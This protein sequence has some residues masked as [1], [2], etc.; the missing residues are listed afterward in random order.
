M[1]NEISIK[2]VYKS[3]PGQGDKWVVCDLNLEIALGEFFCFVG[4]SGCGKTTTLKLIVGLEPVTKGTIEK[5]EDITMIFQSGALFP[6][7]SVWDN[8]AFGLKMENQ[9]KTKIKELTGKYL[10]MVRLTSF[11]DKYPRELSGGQRQRVGI[12]RALAVSPRVLLLDEPFSALD[13]FTTQELH[14]DL[15]KIWRE[16]K[17]TVVMVSHLLE[18]AVILA[19]R[20]GVMKEGKLKGIVD[21]DLRRPRKMED[22]L[23][24]YVNKIKGLIV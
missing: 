13:T 12:A 3:F 1:T 19:D 4:P 17:I 5:P 11:K 8:I 6:W 20:V 10:E 14:E 2:N 21:V 23:F 7:L 18:E 22:D 16:T 15:L 9:S 24:S